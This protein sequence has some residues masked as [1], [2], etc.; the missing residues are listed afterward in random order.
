MTQKELALYQGHHVLQLAAGGGTF[1]FCHQSYL[2]YLVAKHLLGELDTSVSGDGGRKVVAWLGSREKQSLFRREQLRLLLGALRSEAHE[3]YLPTLREFLPLTEPGTASP[4][5][6]HLRLLALQLL[7]QVTDPRVEEVNLVLALL[8]QPFWREHVLEEVVRGQVPWFE[9][10]DDQGKLEAWLSGEDPRLRDLALEMLLS[11]GEKSGDR[12]ARLLA[13]HLE[14]DDAWTRRIIWVLR[15][16]PS[17]DSDALFEIR[18]QLTK[19]GSY[20]ADHVDWAKLAQSHPAHFI[21]L[22]AHVLIALAASISRGENRRRPGRITEIDWFN[23]EKVSSTVIP[24]QYWA[25]A[26]EM[27]FRAVSLVAQV[28][29]YQEEPQHILESY[30]VDFRTLKPVLS[31]LRDLGRALLA[32]NWLEFVT[33]GE[34]LSLL[35]RSGEVLFVDS[36]IEGPANPELAD[37]ALGWLMADPLRAQLRCR[38]SSGAWKLAG[39]LIE[40][41]AP[42]SSLATYQRLEQWLLAYREPDL[43]EN[44]K[45]RHEW[46]G[47]SGDLG[48]ASSFGKT[49]FALMP[50]LPAE[51]RSAEVDS[52]LDQLGRK[53]RLQTPPDEEGDDDSQA[54]L[55]GSPLSE[56]AWARMSDK[57]WLAIAMN[58]RLVARFRMTLRS[59]GRFDV[60]SVETF[61]TDF[62]SMTQRQPERFAKLALRLPP[63]TN[64]A[65]LNAILSGLAF[66]GDRSGQASLEHWTPPSHEVLEE[67]FA[68]PA[69]YSLVCG[70]GHEA[71]KNLCHILARY[72]EYPWSEHAVD[73]LVWIAQHHN[74]PQRDFY[75]V[76]SSGGE[77]ENLD[78]LE[79]NALNVARGTAGFAIRNLLFKRPDLFPTLRPALESLIQDEHPAVRVAALAACLPVINIDR[80]LA[81]GWFLQGC[82]GPDAILATREA[83]DF[84][85][86][87]KQT[88]LD[89]LRPLI[90]H[91]IASPVPRV[92]TAGAFQ[93]AAS[94]LVAGLLA[95]EFERCIRGDPS[96]RKGVAEVAAVLLGEPEFA[97]NAKTTLLRL[98][99]DDDGKVAQ[100]VAR[101]LD[102][103]DLRH[104][105]S[106]REAWNAFA[107][108][109]AF[110]ADPSPLLRAL[111]RQVGNL[112]PFADCLIAVGTTF[113][114]ELAEASRNM[115]TRISGDVRQLLPLL[116]RLYEHAQ[117]HDQAL[118]L[119]CLDLWDYLLERRVGAAMG[120]TNEL[121]QVQATS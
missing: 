96:H 24:S 30:A 69:V 109:K 22:A 63:A 11:V 13:P 75:P 73:L 56:S 72:S 82:E 6:F 51:R 111:D 106:D 117:G 83:R 120:L 61:A 121:D 81:V 37:W 110:K 3:A 47:R 98:A 58:E 36:L 65:F 85:R 28:R 78:T 59:R 68:L 7:G 92:A 16:D 64:P 41:Y 50:R 100:A 43:L 93:V 53:F 77:S 112:L 107:R 2:D 20:T 26:W 62:L 18:L 97:E 67:V 49:A 33:L 9:V 19:T 5:R 34:K 115:T 70:E 71:A 10:L 38:R 4:I 1:S 86:Y 87:T 84:L 44:Y 105:T 15:F 48:E 31:L 94:F 91:M 40:R 12:A 27:L 32:D 57:D 88:H 114:E 89:R 29:A 21:L 119:R 14:Q 76:G 79:T 54:G 101:G 108:S 103:L 23:L 99:E 104:I 60:A 118:Y 116:L 95:E 35:N 66:S 74:D 80:D 25:N 8:D 39:C 42:F 90:E 17:Q 46:I 102:Q 52:R 113:A 45:R 55:V